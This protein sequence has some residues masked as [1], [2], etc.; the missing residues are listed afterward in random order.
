MAE[1]RFGWQ[2]RFEHDPVLLAQ[3]ETQVLPFV[4]VRN[5]RTLLRA[6]LPLRQLT[7]AEAIDLVIA[8]STMALVLANL[9]STRLTLR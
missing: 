8:T 6:V 2:T 9:G 7:P 5:V 3:F 1:T 4:S